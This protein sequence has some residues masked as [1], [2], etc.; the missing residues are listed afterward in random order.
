MR[1]C[2]ICNCDYFAKYDRVNLKE[3]EARVLLRFLKPEHVF[4]ILM[5]PSSSIALA[6][7][8]SLRTAMEIDGAG[9]QTPGH[10]H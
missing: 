5:T 4:E 6:D 3:I 10:H 8:S 1:K 9:A 2:D 7:W